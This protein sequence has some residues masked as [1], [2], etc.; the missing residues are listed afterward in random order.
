[1][2]SW[3]FNILPYL[4]QPAIHDL[5][6][7][8]SYSAKMNIFIQ[9]ESTPLAMFICPTRRKV[10]VAPNFYNTG[11]YNQ[12]PSQTYTHSDYAVNGGDWLPSDLHSDWCDLPYPDQP[13]SISQGDSPQYTWY[14]MVD[15]VTG[16]VKDLTGISYLRSRVKMGDIRDGTSCTYLAAEKY[17]DPDFYDTGQDYGDNEGIYSGYNN[18]LTRY[19]MVLPQQDTPGSYTACPFGS[20]HADSFH[21]AMCDGSVNQINYS[22]ALPI[23]MALANRDDGQHINANAY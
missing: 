21:A 4:E 12:N 15:P 23:H 3:I 8:Q 16:Q 1:M 19:A 11:D 20:A 7:G 2:G 17:M 9:R 6:M 13:S 18:D 5:G 22:I 14:K 10:A